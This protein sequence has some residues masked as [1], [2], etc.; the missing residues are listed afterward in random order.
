MNIEEIA[1]INTYI[2]H[3]N[4]KADCTQQDVIKLCEEAIEHEFAGVCVSPYFVQL[5]K[6]KTQ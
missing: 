3:T 1:D 4:L 6:R 5:A 2:E